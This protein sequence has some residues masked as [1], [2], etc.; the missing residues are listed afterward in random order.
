MPEVARR[1]Y[2]VGIGGIGMSALA[3]WLLAEGWMVHG[4]DHTHSEITDALGR[5]GVAIDRVAPAMLPEGTRLLVY[6]DAVPA[7]DALRMAARAAGVQE[8][9]YAK[10]L[11]ELTR[12]FSTVAIAG[13]HGK[14]T[15]TALT[16]L[17]LEAAGLDPTV[18]VGTRVP[19]W[20]P[21]G[22]HRPPAIG[23]YRRRGQSTLAVVEADEYREHF[24]ALSPTIAVVTSV[25]YD[26]VDAF[27]TPEKYAAAFAAFVQ[28]VGAGG[29]VVLAAQDTAVMRLRSHV[30]TGCAVTT[31]AMSAESD[32]ADVVVTPPV[33]RKS[34]QRFQ[35]TVRGHDWGLL[36]LT[37]PGEH[38][39]HNAAAAVAATLP[40]AVSPDTVRRALEA[41]HGT[42]RRFELVGLANDALV[43]SDYAH[44]PTELR[45][46]AAAARQ[47]YPGRR[48]LIAFQ[49]HQHA[50]TLAFEPEF[51]AA[52]TAFDAVILAEVYDVT[53]RE[54]SKRVTTQRWVKPLSQRVSSVVYA[55][56]LD[57]VAHAVRQQAHADDVVLIV[58]A[59]TIDT[60]A[61]TLVAGT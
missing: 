9:S 4:T 7:G 27:P 24:L 43:I 47:W 2:F 21:R 54:E 50:R 53:G 60:V 26:H 15:T 19:Q 52:L 17:L 35:L 32:T 29:T 18:V 41:F 56:T 20:M 14:S 25:D 51:L 33:F 39:V 6:S 61:R 28:R 37:V 44:H 49:P 58:G 46:L 12:P 42:W 10:L 23:N 13:S 31:F 36:E 59:G 22:A 11:G 57:D 45:A 16:G 5:A 3:Q 34:R 48:V 1:A 40:F 8:I 55:P 30:T 38:V